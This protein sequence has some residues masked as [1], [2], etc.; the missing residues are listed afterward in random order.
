MAS[1]VANEGGVGVISSAGLGLLYRNLSKDYIE[2]SILGLKEELR[3]AKE[4][5]KGV[6]GVN[7]MVAMSN[8]ADM[9]KTAVAE[10]AD[11][12]FSGAGLP[13]NLPS[14]LPKGST[15]NWFLSFLRL[16]QPG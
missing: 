14:F 11:I 1:A 8:F 9:V 2:A 12:I 10:K 16:G 15:T 6:I 3:K 4:K 7:V 13:L 5:T